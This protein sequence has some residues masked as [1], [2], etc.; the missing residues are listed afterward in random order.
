[1]DRVLLLAVRACCVASCEGMLEEVLRRL[2]RSP[3]WRVH[4]VWSLL[5]GTA[6]WDRTYIQP[7]PRANNRLLMILTMH[8]NDPLVDVAAYLFLFTEEIEP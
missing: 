6:C 5:V 2:L 1:M 3:V 8:D 4:R 7:H